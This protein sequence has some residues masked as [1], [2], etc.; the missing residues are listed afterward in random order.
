[1]L[2]IADF[3][4]TDGVRLDQRGVFPNIDVESEKALEKA[5]EIINTNTNNNN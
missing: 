1:M 5:L 2:P 3:Y 4:T